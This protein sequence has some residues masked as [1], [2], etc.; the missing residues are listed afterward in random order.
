MQRGISTRLRRSAA[1]AFV[2]A[3]AGASSAGAQQVQRFGSYFGGTQYPQ[4]TPQPVEGIG[5]VSQIDASN[6]SSLALDT[7]GRVW[8]WGNG[9]YGALGDGLT[10]D[11]TVPVQPSF[12][13]G[14]KIVSIGEAR[15]DS[16]AIDAEGHLWAWGMNESGS[17][18]LGTAKKRQLV[19]R[20]VAGISNAVAVQGAQ[21][22]VLILLA[23]GTLE[24]CGTNSNGQ[25]GVG[26]AVS[27]TSTPLPVPGLS[28]VVEITAGVLT[29]AARTESGA[30]FT[31]GDNRMGQG[32]TG[33]SAGSVFAPTQVVLPGPASEISCGG[34]AT[35]EGDD[36]GFDLA[37]VAGQVYGWGT[38]GHGQIG[39]HRRRSKRTP[40]ATGLHFA[41]VVASG[42]NAIGLTATGDV[43]TWGAGFR[44][45]LGTGNSDSSSI[46]VQVSSG[47]TMISATALN[48]L[49]Y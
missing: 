23:D 1:L 22:H 2:C 10:S 5:A 15:D 41:K 20:R 30:V 35:G 25:L 27:E 46:P 36:S 34:D 6:A 29:S 48:S 38:D 11:A 8:V 19:P 39:D 21:N 31:W 49:I 33:A 16:Y 32:G 42:E 40:V 26:A 3:L 28:H 43:F 7:S 24:A 45:S 9:E 12:P 17:L 47:N 44:Y 14:T 37:L 13:A 18:C 4:P